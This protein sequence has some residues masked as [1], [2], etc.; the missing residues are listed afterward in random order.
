MNP[1]KYRFTYYGVVG[2]ALVA[3]TSCGAS[4]D[5]T[6][7]Y[8]LRDRLSTWPGLAWLDPITPIGEA[9]QSQSDLVY[10]AGT[11]GRHLPLVGQGLYEL[12]DDSGSIWVLSATPPPTVGEPVTLRATIRYEQ[13]LLRG[14]DIGEYYAEELERLPQESP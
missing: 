14:Q 6:V 11:V 4:V 5:A 10:L 7:G 13:I 3:V 1:L 9:G 8:S 2:L 12:V